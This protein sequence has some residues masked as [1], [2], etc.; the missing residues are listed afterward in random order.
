M[1]DG[2]RDSIFGL[3]GETTTSTFDRTEATSL[4]PS[5]ACDPMSGLLVAQVLNILDTLEP[6]ESVETETSQSAHRFVR[7][8]KILSHQKID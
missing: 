7:S 3:S 4:D 2:L 5:L 6:R 1:H 8:R